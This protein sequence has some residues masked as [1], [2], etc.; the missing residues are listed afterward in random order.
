MSLHWMHV[1]AG[2][3]RVVGGFG[4]MALATALRH[5]EAKRTLARLDVR[6]GRA[7]GAA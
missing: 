5:A 2:Y 6:A 1:T 3:V 4:A 7:R